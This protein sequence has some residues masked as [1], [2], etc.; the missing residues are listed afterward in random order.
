MEKGIDNYQ[1]EEDASGLFS[2]GL[3]SG[4]V[5]IFKSGYNTISSGVKH[6]FDTF[7]KSLENKAFFGASVNAQNVT[8][9][10]FFDDVLSEYQ[11][12]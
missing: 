10:S 12:I 4:M 6:A 8:W 11:I 9:H 2:G 1:N 7:I 3:F 5:S